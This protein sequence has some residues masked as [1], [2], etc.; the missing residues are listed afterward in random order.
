[1]TMMVSKPL[2]LW[3]FIFGFLTFASTLY[4][5]DNIIEAPE[6]TENTGNI[7]FDSILEQQ[8]EGEPEKPLSLEDQFTDPDFLMDDGQAYDEY[9][10]AQLRFLNKI[11]AESEEFTLNVG[12]TIAYGSLR[13]RPMTCKKSPPIEEP[14]SVAFLQIWEKFR[15]A[16][17]DEWVFSG[18][19]FASAPSLSSMEHPIYD[20]WV[21]DCLD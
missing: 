13:I 9:G 4:A 17:E 21:E 7:V 15:D 1:M 8:L 10:K 14:E 6:P 3:L 18:W 5:Q 19:M 16:R 11:T 12:E 2:A 20:I